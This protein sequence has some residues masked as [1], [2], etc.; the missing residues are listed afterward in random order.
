MAYNEFLADR[1]SQMLD[2]KAGR[3][4]GLKLY[5]SMLVFG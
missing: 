4:I 2:D 5:M 1:I 3:F